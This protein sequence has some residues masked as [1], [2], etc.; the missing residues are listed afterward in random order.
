MNDRI[1]KARHHLAEA[2]DCADPRLEERIR[3]LDEE[4]ET[5]DGDVTRGG[6]TPRGHVLQLEAEFLDLPEAAQGQTRLH[7]KHA[8]RLVT[9]YRRTHDFE[10]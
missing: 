10:A 7:I 6:H 1:S 8:M 2:S 3:S 4:L 5:V 9:E